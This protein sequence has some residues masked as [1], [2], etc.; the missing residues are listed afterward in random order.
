M[1]WVLRLSDATQILGAVIAYLY[2]HQTGVL[3]FRCFRP[4][5][6]ILLQI[7]LVME[8][9]WAFILYET[10]E[11][12]CGLWNWGC[13]LSLEDLIRSI[14]AINLKSSTAL[15]ISYL[16]LSTRLSSLIAT[17]WRWLLLVKDN[18]STT[19]IFSLCISLTS[20]DIM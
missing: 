7:F 12:C 9:F 8:A 13:F 2:Y 20:L 15:T 3:L 4:W 18:L 5:V 14:R 19:I 17:Y 11:I 16:L 1:N 6:K 10:H